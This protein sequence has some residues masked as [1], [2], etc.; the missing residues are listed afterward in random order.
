MAENPIVNEGKIAV[1]IKGQLM[2]LRLWLI[3][4]LPHQSINFYLKKFIFEFAQILCEIFVINAFRLSF[5]NVV[6]K[7]L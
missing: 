7:L 2:N 5:F 6:E 1:L 4:D 3:G